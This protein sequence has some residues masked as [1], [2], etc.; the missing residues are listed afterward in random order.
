MEPG[1]RG[2]WQLST[3][4]TS[5]WWSTSVMMRSYTDS[6]FLPTS[7]PWS[8]PWQVLKVLRDGASP[9]TRSRS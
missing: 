7:I 1:W 6:T 5:P 2:A 4:W 9:P 8:T 3:T